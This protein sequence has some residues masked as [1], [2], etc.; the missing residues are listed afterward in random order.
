MYK[1][2]GQEDRFTIKVVALEKVGDYECYRLEATL[3]DKPVGT[4]HL[5]SAKNGIFRVRTDRDD[6]I[7]P[8]CILQIP[9]KK[10]SSWKGDYK[11]GGKA[12][13]AGFTVDTEA[14]TVPAGKFNAVSVQAELNEPTGRVR[15]TLWF[16]EN[17]GVVKQTLEEGKRTLTLEL[18]KFT[19]AGKK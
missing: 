15:T 4:E 2:S 16:V 10:G 7:P 5:L 3:R 19:K 18:E 8:V 6:V 13:S 1:V 14:I 17:V 11:L 9:A 12:A